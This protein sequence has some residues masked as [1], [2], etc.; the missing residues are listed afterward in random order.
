[1]NKNTV[2]GDIIDWQLRQ[3]G[4]SN[5]TF[6]N[7][8]MY[9]VDFKL[10][11][12]LLVSYVFNITRGDKYFLQRMRP[13]AMVQGKYANTAEIAEFIEKDLSKFRNAERSSNFVKFIEISKKGAEFAEALENLFLNYNVGREEMESMEEKLDRLLEHIGQAKEKA[14][15]EEEDARTTKQYYEMKVKQLESIT[16][17][18]AN[19]SEQL[20]EA[21]AAF[22][23]S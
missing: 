17:A 15:Q 2:S 4:A 7:S 5:I 6:V 8:N 10:E 13:Y 9:I 23:E 19:V 3:M 18:L 1:M 16:K 12:G 11:G 14:A 21:M 22:Q 20:K